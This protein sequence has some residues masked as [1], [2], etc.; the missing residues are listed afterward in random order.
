MHR[1]CKNTTVFGVCVDAD[2]ASLQR[3]Q[4]ASIFDGAFLQGGAIFFLSDFF[5]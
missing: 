5:L 4:V 3:K 1:F 2:A